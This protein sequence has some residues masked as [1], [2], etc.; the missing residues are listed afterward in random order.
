MGA[1]NNKINGNDTFQDVY[2]TYFE[3]YNEGQNPVDVSK[4]IKSEF[5][6]N[7]EDYDERNDSL[8][9]LA[10]AQWETK[11][12]DKTIFK[13]VKEIIESGNDLKVWKG[14]GADEKTLKERKKYLE[15]FLLQI[16]AIKEKPKRRVLKKFD[17][18]VISLIDALAPDNL[19]KFEVNEEYRDKRYIH[20]SGLMMW[21]DGGGSVLYFEGQGKKIS[22]IWLNSKTIEI[23]HDKDI[24][25]QM[26]ENSTFYFGD[27]IKIIYKS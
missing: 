15:K 17:F 16:S 1:W 11:V 2:Q 20:T 4:H 19:K 3:L 22:A 12:V 23:T 8:F 13:Q 5:A 24:I 7:F 6:I 21:A 18:E 25:F 27:D 9:A 26:K 14:L 10:L